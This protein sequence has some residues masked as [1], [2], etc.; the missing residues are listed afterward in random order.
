LACFVRRHALSLRF[1]AP[2]FLRHR[3]PLFLHTVIPAS[4]AFVYS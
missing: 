4:I 2:L 3:E 1:R